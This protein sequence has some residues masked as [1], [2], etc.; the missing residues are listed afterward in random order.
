M[1]RRSFYDQAHPFPGKKERR[2]DCH[3][4][5]GVAFRSQVAAASVR[6]AV[7]STNTNPPA[8]MIAEKGAALIKAATREK[9]AT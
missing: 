5:P 3:R 7:G 1:P 8:I 2:T 9:L 6:L 4:S